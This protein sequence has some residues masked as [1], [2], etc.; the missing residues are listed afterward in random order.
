MAFLRA[1]KYAVLGGAFLM[2]G[3][4]W[5]HHYYSHGPAPVGT[6]IVYV[7]HSPPPPRRAH[8]PPRPSPGAFWIDG[9]WRWSG[10]EFVWT[11]GRWD[12]SPPPG[13]VWVP[14]RWTHSKRGWYWT[15][16]RWR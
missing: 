4:C 2:I 12:R 5:Y 7:R 3:G 15:D 6:S 16:G 13:K 1:L 11:D 10:V 14:G 9:Y 8:I